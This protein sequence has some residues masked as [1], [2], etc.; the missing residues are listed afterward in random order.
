MGIFSYPSQRVQDWLSQEWCI[1]TGRRI[2]PDEH[3]WLM[4][5]FG[6]VDVIEDQYVERLAR[7]ENLDVRKNEPG[8]GL[9][10]SLDEW[11]LTAEQASSLHP[12]I[13]RFYERSIE[14]ELEVWFRWCRLFHPGAKLISI[15][16]SRR[17]QQ[18]NLPLDPL[19]TAR[20]IRSQIYR[21]Y[22]T[23]QRVRHT[24]WYR[25]LKSTG[26]VI[27]SGVYSNCRLPSGETA[28]KVIF[29]LPRGNATVVMRIGVLEDGSLDLVSSGSGFGDA[30]FYFLLNDAKMRHHAKYL[31]SFRERIHVY[32]DKEETLRAD[33]TMSVWNKTA[34]RLHYKITPIP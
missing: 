7:E 1:F 12:E 6:N 24:I 19:D 22:D 31:R 2:D 9:V 29:P 21:L 25:H 27:Y 23:S 20:G 4:G 5:P 13:R 33:H 18:L 16:Y 32:V 34:L 14:Y 28:L 11:N 10:P 26:D 8:A 15:L 3:P 30:G 17:L